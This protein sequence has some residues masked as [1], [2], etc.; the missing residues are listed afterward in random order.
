MHVIIQPATIQSQSESWVILEL[1][2]CI[3]VLPR[4]IFVAGL[5]RGKAWRRAES[6]RARMAAAVEPLACNSDPRPRVQRP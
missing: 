2:M 4:D 3:V 1:P 5:K 6:L